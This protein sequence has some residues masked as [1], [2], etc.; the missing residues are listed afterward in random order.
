MMMMKD[1]QLRAGERH[2]HGL[3][4][5][6]M[7]FCR[8]SSYLLRHSVHN[9]CI[10]LPAGILKTLY[11]SVLYVLAWFGYLVVVKCADDNLSWFLWCALKGSE[12]SQATSEL[13][14]SK[15]GAYFFSPIIH[16]S[17]SR[18]LPRS[19]NRRW[20]PAQQRYSFALVGAADRYHAMSLSGFATSPWHRWLIPLSVVNFMQHVV[21]TR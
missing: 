15:E 9:Y 1:L 18:L 8:H 2:H 11:S 14:S 7:S 17:L 20:D 16:S 13:V 12:A 21:F 6:M 5:T 3:G 19:S 4:D 10:S